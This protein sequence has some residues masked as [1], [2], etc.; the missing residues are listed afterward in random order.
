MLNHQS[1]NMLQVIEST[2]GKCRKTQGYKPLEV[3]YRALQIE[4]LVAEIARP[5]HR[6]HCAW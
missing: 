4:Q 1:R 6:V 5:A 3:S 2:A